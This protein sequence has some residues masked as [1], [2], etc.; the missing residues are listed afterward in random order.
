M[1]LISI[2]LVLRYSATNE[3]TKITQTS[4]TLID[5]IITNTENIAAKAIVD[6]KIPDHE[7]IDILIEVRNECQVPK[8]KE[9]CVFIYNKNRFRRK[10]GSMLEFEEIDDLNEYVGKFDLCFDNMVEHFTVR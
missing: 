1:I 9:C 6:N 7:L 4:K 5:Y 3:F 2:R 8:N 10:L